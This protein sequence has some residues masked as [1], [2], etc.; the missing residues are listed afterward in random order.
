MHK[1]FTITITTHKGAK[2]LR[3]SFSWLRAVV[4]SGLVVVAS[5]LGSAGLGIYFYKDAEQ[6]QSSLQATRSDLSELHSLN[7]ELQQISLTKDGVIS[8]VQQKYQTARAKADALTLAA[9]NSERVKRYLLSRLPN[10]RPIYSRVVT[11]SYGERLD[12]ITGEREFHGGLDMR[13]AIGT[14]V[15][16]T[17]DGVVEFAGDHKRSGYGQLVMVRH[18]FGFRTIYAHLSKTLVKAGSFVGK[19]DVI[20]LSGNSGKSSG[21]HLHYEVRFVHR[22]LDP[23]R[24]VRWSADTYDTIFEERRVRWHS[25]VK[26]LNRRLSD[27]IQPS[28]QLAQK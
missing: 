20:A 27:P 10:G 21:P 17:A 15:R 6:L 23:A 22:K 16:A 28:L 3:V 26:L 19:G 12:P 14:E 7:L 11:S 5:L 24:F 1:H 25:L 13:A 8:E 18:D 4:I 2:H 9:T